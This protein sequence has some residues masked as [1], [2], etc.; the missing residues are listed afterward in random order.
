MRLKG[1]DDGFNDN[2]ESRAIVIHGASYVS[3]AFAKTQGRIGRSWGCPAVRAGVVPE[4]QAEA[5]KPKLDRTLRLRAIRR[6]QSAKKPEPETPAPK[7]R[8][9]P[10]P[11]A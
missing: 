11:K 4:F 7:R 5:F 1:L 2:A 10:K 8:S 6:L 3:P 9:K